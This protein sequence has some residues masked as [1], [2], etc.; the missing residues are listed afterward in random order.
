VGHVDDAKERAQQTLNDED[1]AAAILD[2][3]L[4]HGRFIH[5]DGPS[6][7]TRRLNLEEAFAPA[8]ERARI[9][10][11]HKAEFFQSLSER[12][13]SSAI[14]FDPAGLFGIQLRESCSGDCQ[15]RSE[16]SGAWL[17]CSA[18]V[19]YVRR[20]WLPNCRSSGRTD[21]PERRARS[22][23]FRASGGT[24]AS[25]RIV[26]EVELKSLV[27]E[28]LSDSLDS[29]ERIRSLGQVRSKVRI[30]HRFALPNPRPNRL[31]RSLASVPPIACRI[32]RCS[33]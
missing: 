29:V 11:T 23:K 14:S 13:S 17:L 28:D 16:P 26:E 8:A 15:G 5:L 3:I 4:E 6:W 31:L 20:N 2:R 21:Q 25:A 32:L 12:S 7:R 27:L 22:G 24:G 33:D 10:G 30:V 9:S 18:K 1:L 19:R